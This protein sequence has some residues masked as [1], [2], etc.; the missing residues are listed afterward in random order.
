MKF[1]LYIRLKEINSTY[2]QQEFDSLAS[3]L[4]YII[5]TQ[6]KEAGY[7]FVLTNTKTVV[8]QGSNPTISLT[9]PTISGINTLDIKINF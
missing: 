4:E 7:D 2:T 3:T 6:G 5:Q 8:A 1:Y 9:A